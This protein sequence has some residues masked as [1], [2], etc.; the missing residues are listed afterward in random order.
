MLANRLS[1]DPDTS[2]LL[3]EAGGDDADNFMI[4]IP[5]LFALNLGSKEDWS[6]YTVP[7]KYSNLGHKNRVHIYIKSIGTP[8]FHDQ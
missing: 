1:E 4:H 2:V 3:V 6:Y 5:A 8:T 7:Q